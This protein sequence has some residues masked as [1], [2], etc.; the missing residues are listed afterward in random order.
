MRGEL[1][2]FSF[3]RDALEVIVGDA[4]DVVVLLNVV[5]KI[6]SPDELVEGDRWSIGQFAELLLELVE[7]LVVV[8]GGEQV[9]DGDRLVGLGLP[10]LSD[11]VLG[12]S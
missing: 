9:E 10:D 11:E 1:D 7:A 5:S 12:Y 8:V 3:R 4:H 2:D 6:L